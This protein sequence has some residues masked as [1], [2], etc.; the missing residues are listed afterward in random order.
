V[1]DPPFILPAGL[2]IQQWRSGILE[3]VE[4]FQRVFPG[5]SARV[6]RPRLNPEVPFFEDQ[7]SCFALLHRRAFPA[8]AKTVRVNRA[9]QDVLATKGVCAAAR[10]STFVAQC[11]RQWL[12]NLNHSFDLRQQFAAPALP[13][14]H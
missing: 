3:F 12:T 6:N 8:T 5:G 9:G 11:G 13:F 7:C 10:V 14:P 2:E 4:E 1:D